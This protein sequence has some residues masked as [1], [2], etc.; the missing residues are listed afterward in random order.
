MNEKQTSLLTFGLFVVF[1]C[2]LVGFG[3]I[4][5]LSGG[6]DFRGYYGAALLVREGGNPYDYRQLAPVL[7]RVTGFMG[8]NPYF[9]PPWFCLFF[10]P[11]T[12]LPFA[13]ARAVWLAFNVFLFWGTLELIMR[14]LGWKYATWHK[15]LLYLGLLFM[16]GIYCLR[17]EQA[18]F[19]L[20]LG[21]ALFV[22]A[23]QQEKPIWA[24]L[25][26]VLLLTK[27]QATFLLLFCLGVWA[28]VK[29][30]PIALWTGV[31][32]GGL[33]AVST[34]F[35]PRWWSFNREGFGAGLSVELDGADAVAAER[36]NTT[37]SDFLA[38]QFSIDPPVQTIIIGLMVI[39]A[40]ILIG[41]SWW[42]T[43]N[44]LILLQSSLLATLLITPYT[45]QYDY[46]PLAFVVIWSLI[47]LSN[48]PSKRR[49]IIWGLLLISILVPLLQSWSYQG[50]W[51]L[52]AVF[53]MYSAVLFSS[54]KTN[55][56][57]SATPRT[58]L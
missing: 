5:W 31:W 6:V 11:L 23:W 37:L 25:G 50:Y 34:L 10:I 40:F 4:A 38:F 58:G 32:V 19:L 30:R 12:F 44:V 1:I 41:Y 54:H 39:L 36:V 20:L 8:N 47:T 18:G 26:V 28:L 35:I 27:P 13:V 16:F 46:P 2:C 9:Y 51:L 22:W 14:T 52:L 15:Y 17:S 21:V 3:V 24:G 42:R 55:A 49:G 33:T 48:V 45:L 57:P 43:Q 53:G 7:E 29:N 56:T